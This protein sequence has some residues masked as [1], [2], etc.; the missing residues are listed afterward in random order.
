MPQPIT[1]P[2]T[3]QT[4]RMLKVDI[5]R[6]PGLGK[7]AYSTVPAYPLKMKVPASDAG[8]ASSAALSRQSGETT[9]K[10]PIAGSL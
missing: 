5:T 8:A 9:F 2:V 7:A 1:A 4:L 3:Y 10:R 6:R